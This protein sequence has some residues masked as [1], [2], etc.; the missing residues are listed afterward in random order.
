MRPFMDAIAIPTFGEKCRGRPVRWPGTSFDSVS[1]LN[2][3]GGHTR[4]FHGLYAWRLN[5]S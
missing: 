3:D 1:S 4:D 2:K 5:L